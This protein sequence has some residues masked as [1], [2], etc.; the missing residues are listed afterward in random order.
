MKK[1][2]ILAATICCVLI[3]S[4]IAITY[5]PKS[6]TYDVTAA[7]YPIVDYNSMQ[8]DLVGKNNDGN[9]WEYAYVNQMYWYTQKPFSSHQNYSGPSDYLVLMIYQNGSASSGTYPSG[10]ITYTIDSNPFNVV[11]PS[12]TTSGG[13]EFLY[14]CR[15]IYLLWSN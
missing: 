1:V 11:I 6:V 8:L 14:W 12:F 7:S 10:S 4:S 5:S 13:F 15:W 2:V 3:Q 9:S